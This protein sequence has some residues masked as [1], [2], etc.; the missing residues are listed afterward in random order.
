MD[1][2]LTHTSQIIIPV[3]APVAVPASE[4]IRVR[5][6]AIERDDLSLLRD[7]R[8]AVVRYCREWRP[9]GMADQD[10][11]FARITGPDRERHVMFLIE[12]DGVLSSPQPIGVC[13]FTDHDWRC[14]RA[15]VS[16]YIGEPS[17]M[18]HGFG[19]DALAALLDF[20]FCE[21]GLNRVI[22]E[23][24]EFNNASLRLFEGF[25]FRRE[26]VLRAHHYT[27]GRWWDS[28]LFGLLKSEWRAVP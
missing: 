3:D 28:V 27:E 25:G 16:L 20:G 1:P 13:G 21:M 10:A 8:N 4:D 6:R 15:D 18:G 7:W 17:A 2:K 23:V 26:G 14:R 22:A 24:F 12:V 5:L 9:L 11:W 19:R